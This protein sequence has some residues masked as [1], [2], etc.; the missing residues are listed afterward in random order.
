V[1]RS[2]RRRAF[3]AGRSATGLAVVA[4]IGAASQ[5]AA[6]PDGRGGPEPGGGTRAV[7][8]AQG[9]ADAPAGDPAAPA[10]PPASSADSSAPGADPPVPP[11]RANPLARLPLIG[12][13]FGEA[14]PDGDGDKVAPHYALDVVA[15]DPV[16]RQIREFT[17][18]GRWR[19]RA[20]Y[21]PSQLPLFV[22]R[23]EGEVRELMAAEGWF[24]SEVRVERTEAGVRIEV[25]AGPR[26][27]VGDVALRL[28]GP[29]AEP[30][31]TPVRER[32]ERRWPMPEGAPFRSSEWERAKRELVGAL[33]DAGF[34]RARIV[35]SEAIV[36]Q[37]RAKASL[38]IDVESG[39]PLRFG[40]LDIRGLQ[41]YPSEVVR[42]LAPFSEGDPYDAGRIAQFQTRLGGAGWFS[43]VN[44]RPDT[45]ELQRDP[46]L[47]EVPIRVDV[48]ERQAKR[49]TVGGGYDTDRGFSVLTAWEYRNVLG[50]GVQTFNGVEVD[51]QR[52]IVYST[53][54]TPQDLRGLRWQF[55]VRAEH[56]D[57]QNDLTDAGL[58]F[59]SRNLRIGDDEFAATLQ[60]QVEWQN[61]VFGPGDEANYYNRALVPGLSWTR[62]RLDSPLFPTRGYIVSA[63]LSGAS[64]AV[65]SERSFVRA[66]GLAY[67]IVPLI[68]TDRQEFGRLVVRG[69]VGAVEASSRDGIPSANLFR[70]GGAKSVRGYGSQDLGVPIG[71]AVL[72]G[73]YLWVGSLEY[74]HLLNRDLAL[75]VFYDRG[76][77]ADSWTAL[78]PVAGYGAGIR[79]RTPVGPLNLD[80]AWGEA[81]SSWR[82]HFSIGVVF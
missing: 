51:Q 74:Q 27:V 30:T 5:A 60:Y 42:G 77:A 71:E 43:T 23:A 78:D 22:R 14:D 70:T 26:T 21:D 38:S 65:L 48:V 12:R 17:L 63:Q 49:W 69:E 41:R 15:P 73:R 9:P 29:V 3:A 76:N 62:R 13:F 7:Q 18:L 32:I 72:G 37:D 66:Y 57:I 61:V 75:A 2:A 16:A 56:R 6:A 11:K 50:L 25:E 28:G 44:V 8:L 68:G 33:G 82:L 54:E 4:L 1:E 46:D 24:S 58:A 39:D 79:W 35:D 47:E 19:N 20:D 59:V 34:L 10:V 55:G 31:W 80:V 81:V 40:P 52:Q 53:W 64:S 67:G 45:T 36:E